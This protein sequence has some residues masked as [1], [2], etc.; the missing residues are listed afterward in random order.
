MK[1]NFIKK[2]NVACEAVPLEN[3]AQWPE[4]ETSFSNVKILCSREKVSA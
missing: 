3:A 1:V 2:N 4:K